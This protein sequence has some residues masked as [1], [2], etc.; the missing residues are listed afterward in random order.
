MNILDP[1][2]KYTPAAKTDIAKTFKRIHREMAEAKKQQ[3]RDE[4]ERI[5]KVKPMTRSA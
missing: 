4:L 2:F 1:K 5:Q 3:E